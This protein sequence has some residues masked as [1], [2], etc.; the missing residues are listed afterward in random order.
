MPVNWD[1]SWKSEPP[2]PVFRCSLSEAFSQTGEPSFTLQAEPPIANLCHAVS[3]WQVEQNLRT[4]PPAT[5]VA[6]S[7]SDNWI[8]WRRAQQFVQKTMIGGSV[9]LDSILG[10]GEDWP[11]VS[12]FGAMGTSTEPLGCS[13][14]ILAVGQR[15]F[16]R[17]RL[18]R[19]F[20]LPGDY[21][22]RAIRRQK[23]IHVSA[24][25]GMKGF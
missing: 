14:P 13:T 24:Q 10:R 6:R 3:F 8:K 15:L 17:G 25:I 7:W 19:G 23:L 12:S 5:K 22:V 4:D 2:R 21:R 1:T 9:I 11:G 16:R 20:S 18:I